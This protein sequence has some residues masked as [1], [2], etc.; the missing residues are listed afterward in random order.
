MYLLL[1]LFY[2]IRNGTVWLK[3]Y[4]YFIH[5]AVPLCVKTQSPA[6]SFVRWFLVGPPGGEHCKLNQGAS[7]TWVELIKG[8]TRPYLN[9]I[10][11][12][13]TGANPEIKAAS[14]SYFVFSP[15]LRS[16][17]YKFRHSCEGAYFLKTSATV[18]LFTERERRK[19]K[20]QLGF[21]W[22][23]FQGF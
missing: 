3:L 9:Q 16:H 15:R 20:D 22:L 2:K 18:C 17:L 8:I 14:G 23:T 7:W 6:G 5:D 21:H 19:E 4:K 12:N 1:D 11:Y 13:C 10:S